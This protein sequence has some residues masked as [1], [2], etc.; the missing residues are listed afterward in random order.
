MEMK[1]L[2]KVDKMRFPKNKSAVKAFLD[3]L[4]FESFVVKGF[5]V[6]E[7]DKG[8]F[9]GFPREKVNEKYFNTAYPINREARSTLT[10][11]ILTYYKENK[12]AV[13]TKEDKS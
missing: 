3:V 6:V 5:R 4:F 1:G 10:D 12:D 7:S 13:P 9:V 2:I 8:L 11:L